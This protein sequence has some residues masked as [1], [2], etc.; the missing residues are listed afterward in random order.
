[1]RRAFKVI[2]Q[3]LVETFQDKDFKFVID[4]PLR[5]IHPVLIKC[6]ILTVSGKRPGV[7]DPADLKFKL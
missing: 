4:S 3:A 2:N 7:H 1:M 6:D 5:I